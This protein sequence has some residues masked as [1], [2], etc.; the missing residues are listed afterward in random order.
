MLGILVKEAQSLKTLFV[1][2]EVD[3]A[4]EIFAHG[5][6]FEAEFA[7]PGLNDAVEIV[8]FETVIARVVKYGCEVERTLVHCSL[9]DRPKGKNERLAGQAHPFLGQVPRQI[10]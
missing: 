2:L 7:G 3:V 9:A 6:F 8:R 5:V 1:K 4:A 10:A